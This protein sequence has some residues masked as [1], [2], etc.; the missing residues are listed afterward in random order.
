MDRSITDVLDSDAR[1]QEPEELTT[2]L[3][4]SVNFPAADCGGVL[5]RRLGA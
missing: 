1:E 3:S 5:R 4:L 2:A